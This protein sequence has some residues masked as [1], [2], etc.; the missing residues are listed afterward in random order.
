MFRALNVALVAFLSLA[1]AG[2][3]SA[4]G[5]P[6]KATN[7]WKGS[8]EDGKLQSKCPENGVITKAEDWKNLV[9]EWKIADKVPEINFDKELIVIAVSVGSKIDVSATVDDKG[10]LRVL[11]L[12]T[13]DIRPGFRYSII[14]VPNDGVKTVNG[15]PLSK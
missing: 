12:G 14:S 6:L 1:V 10:N 5:K 8:V 7:T 13:R 3:V 4:A 11:G 15:K 2:V 9:K